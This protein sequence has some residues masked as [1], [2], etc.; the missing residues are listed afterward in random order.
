MDKEKV[1]RE[2]GIEEPEGRKYRA[3]RGFLLNTRIGPTESIPPGA[4]VIVSETTGRE[5]FGA[6]K[7]RPETLSEEFQVVIPFVAVINGEFS[8]LNPGDVIK[9]D[10]DEAL[11]YLKKGYVKEGR[12]T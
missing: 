5:L 8:A 9:L 7:I 4:L 11:E 6:G 1:F 3:L 12:G 2:F 10:I